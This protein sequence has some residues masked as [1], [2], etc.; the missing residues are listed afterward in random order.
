V[1]FVLIVSYVEASLN[2]SKAHLDMFFESKT[3][4]FN[5]FV[6]QN[7]NQTKDRETVLFHKSRREAPYHRQTVFF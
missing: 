2:V 4:P 3:T 7:L 6:L 5:F 1:W